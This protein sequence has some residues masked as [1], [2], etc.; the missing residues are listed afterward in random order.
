MSVRW[1][2]EDDLWLWTN[3]S[4]P[5]KTLADKF[6]RGDGAIRSRLKHLDDPAHAAYT[7][8]NGSTT[9]SQEEAPASSRIQHE[10]K[11]PKFE[12]IVKEILLPPSIASSL[13]EVTG[14]RPLITSRTMNAVHHEYNVPGDCL[15]EGQLKAAK[16]VLR[17]GSNCFLTGA[18]GVGRIKFHLNP[19]TLVNIE[20]TT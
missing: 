6:N 8:L 5:T 20:S 7:R 10:T 16:T 17:D 19:L 11:R 13:D 12:A 9:L 1:T 3:R 14:T 18:A 4:L 2:A 15:N